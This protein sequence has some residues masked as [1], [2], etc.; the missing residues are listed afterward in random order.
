MLSD[1]KN[2]ILVVD[3]DPMNILILEEILGKKY[4][5]IRAETAEAACLEAA[6]QRP[7]LILIDLMVEN[8]SGYEVCRKLR[9]NS[10]LKF[11]KIILVSSKSLLKDRLFGYDAGADDYLSR[12]FD[13]DELMAKVKVFIRLKYVEEVDKAK[14]DLIN[15]FAHETRTPLNA[16]IGFAKLLE[17]NP[18]ISTDDKEFVKLII[19]SGLSLLNL[20]NKAILLS[21]LRKENAAL[22]L[23]ET[24]LSKL[25]DNAIMAL[26]EAL[27]DKHIRLE[28]KIQDVKLK[29]DCNLTETAIAYILDNAYKFTAPEATV[30]ISSSFNDAQDLII[31]FKDSG[32][33][34]SQNRLKTIFDEF[35]V[36]DVSHHGRGHGLSLAAVKLII[37]HH[38]GS[39]TL[40]NNSDG[41]G[42]TCL[43]RFP[44][45]S[46]IID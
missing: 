24:T 25:I 3:D 30:E 46:I 14:D 44:A 38:N 35:V 13:P 11:T 43:L 23:S 10:E 17:E 31:S 41:Q 28:R 6:R 7:D 21:S 20:S 5:L 16:I 37:E 8:S 22:T 34:I 4:Q 9:T 32:C 40:N 1:K 2:K 33:G 39:V 18:E 12:P 29:V 19:D 27:K 15:L 42:V 26:P 36:E 45:S